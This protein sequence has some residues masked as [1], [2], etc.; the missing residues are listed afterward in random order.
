MEEKLTRSISV[1]RA[2]KV[3]ALATWDSFSPPLEE[4]EKNEENLW[5][6]VI[7]WTTWNLIREMIGKT[8]H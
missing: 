1:R 6:M 4:K 3:G 7:T 8:W 2:R 5:M